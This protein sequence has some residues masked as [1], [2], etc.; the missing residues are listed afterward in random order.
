MKAKYQ[1]LEIFKID[2]FETTKLSNKVE[3]EPQGS[4]LNYK[5]IIEG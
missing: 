5:N 3:F 4:F 1:F 2:A